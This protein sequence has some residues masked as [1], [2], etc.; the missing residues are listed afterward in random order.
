MN[1]KISS[2]IKVGRLEI[3]ENKLREKSGE[4][5][6]G[7]GTRI[8]GDFRYNRLLGYKVK[9]DRLSKALIEKYKRWP[10]ASD[11]FNEMQDLK[12]YSK[13]V[14][15]WNSFTKDSLG[16]ARKELL[17]RVM[18]DLIYEDIKSE[19]DP[20]KIDIDEKVMAFVIGLWA[21]DGGFV[22]E[23]GICYVSLTRPF[24]GELI[25]SIA[26]KSN[27]QFHVSNIASGTD[28]RMI[29]LVL[30][31]G[32][33]L[34]DS[35][36][37]SFIKLAAW[38]KQVFGGP[39]EKSTTLHPHPVPIRAWPIELQRLYCLGYFCGDGSVSIYR[40]RGNISHRINLFHVP[41]FLTKT[42]KSDCGSLIEYALDKT[43]QV[44]TG[45]TNYIALRH[46]G[47]VTLAD[48]W[49]KFQRSYKLPS[50]YKTDVLMCA[51]FLCYTDNKNPSI[52]LLDPLVK[53]NFVTKPSDINEITARVLLSLPEVDRSKEVVKRIPIN[54]L[55]FDPFHN[56]H[57]S[58]SVQRSKAATCKERIYQ[59]YQSIMD[60]TGHPA[61]VRQLGEKIKNDKEL[62]QHFTDCDVASIGK[63][64]IDSLPK[65]E[66]IERVN[67]FG[68]FKRSAPNL[69]VYQEAKAKHRMVWEPI[70]EKFVENEEAR[71]GK[72]YVAPRLMNENG[73]KQ[74]IDS[75]IKYYKKLEMNMTTK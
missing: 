60:K 13:S 71:F 70:L 6:L 63:K 7:Q 14:S 28:D 29:R 58:K 55:F 54:S 67:N 18:L 23:N 26:D 10:K 37:K 66:V 39:V 69:V 47:V 16:R 20:L 73:R 34:A 32:T 46:K 59:F 22:F 41:S 11:F 27:G 50:C 19:F 72:R 62:G 53:I 4:A 57:K 51:E 25:K 40:E 42:F 15:G 65:K 30:A 45:N 44:N 31:P 49:V 61:T 36:D 68:L 48:S 21:A 3:V 75:M 74:I 38:C 12:Y 56:S 2:E 1:C 9:S 24:F 8:E 33:S 64:F 52:N 5:F 17:T 35:D 43:H